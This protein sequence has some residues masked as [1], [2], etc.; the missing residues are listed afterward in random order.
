MSTYRLHELFQPERVAVAGASARPGSLGKVVFDNLRLGGFRGGIDAINPRHKTVDGVRS[1]PRVSDLL[2]PPDVLVVATPA[3]AVPSVIDDA[4]KSGVKAVVLLT[5]G[6]GKGPKSLA[7]AVHDIA[8]RAG[9][10]IVGPNCLGILSPSVAL[11]ASFSARTPQAGHLA[12]V[13]QSGAV[14]AGIIEWSVERK[15]G[16][17]GIVSL[18]DSIDVDFGDCLDYFA[19]D[20]STHAILLYVEAVTDAKKF[21]SAARAAARVKPVIVIKA[22]RHAQAAKAATTHTGALAGVDSVYDAAFRRA[23]L[24]RAVDLDD[25]FSAAETLARQQPFPGERLAILT[26]GGGLGVLAV[27]RLLD[28]GGALSESITQDETGA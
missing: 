19:E 14:A 17:S 20:A 11:N 22:G 7:Q 2:A 10:R 27:D 25:L 8:R 15:V 9:L 12:L 28:F 13:S 6:L 26:N 21:M 3:E 16:F 1:W 18:G 23:G 5:A 24:I 4:A